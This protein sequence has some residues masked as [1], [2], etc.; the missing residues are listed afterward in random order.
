MR[1]GCL[2]FSPLACAQ[3]KHL[4]RVD[5]SLA[6]LLLLVLLLSQTKNCHMKNRHLQAWECG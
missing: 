6:F 4:N 3:C 2:E 1:D 5:R